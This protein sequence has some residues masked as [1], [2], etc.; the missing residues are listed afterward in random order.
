ME[1]RATENLDLFAGGGRNRALYEGVK[2]HQ[3]RN[4][5]KLFGAEHGKKG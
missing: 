3:R 4:F 2:D 1:E 5:L